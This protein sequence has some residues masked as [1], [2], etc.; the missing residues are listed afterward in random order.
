MNIYYRLTIKKTGE[1]TTRKQGVKSDL[2]NIAKEV[3][4][5]N[6]EVG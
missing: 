5:I 3:Y 1:I 2:L 4:L 6:K